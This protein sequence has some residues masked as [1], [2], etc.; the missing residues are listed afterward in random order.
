MMIEEILDA[1]SRFADAL[2]DLHAA[3]T[4]VLACQASAPEWMH[5]EARFHDAQS[6]TFAAQEQLLKAVSEWRE[7]K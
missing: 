3:R 6:E 2:T 1:A 5:V 7:A 4:Q